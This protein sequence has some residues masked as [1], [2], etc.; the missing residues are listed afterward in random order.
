MSVIINPRGTSGSG[1][2]E[3]VRRVLAEYGWQP[4]TDG[5]S[6]ST[7]EPI[8]RA[9]R[10]RPFG[11]RLRHPVG[12]RPLV[13]FGHYEAT[14]GGCDTI[15]ASDGGI[16]EVIARAGEYAAGGHDVIIEGLRLSSEVEHSAELAQ[17]HRLHVLRLS[18]PLDRCVRNLVSRRRAGRDAMP[19]IRRTTADEDL[20]VG[21]ACKRLSGEAAVEILSFDEALSRALFLLGLRIRRIDIPIAPTS[22][23]KAQMLKATTVRKRSCSNAISEP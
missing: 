22:R 14:S 7:F 8:F 9:G 17:R 2:T 20:R 23:C 4:R 5:E 3:L 1:K 6:R 12:G 18:T 16:P 13:V 21:E 11:Y 19:S 15:R 10:S